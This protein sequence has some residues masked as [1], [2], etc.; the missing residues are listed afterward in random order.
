MAS[1][2]N[3]TPDPQKVFSE[4]INGRA[5]MLGLTI[6]LAVE[7]LTGKGI[8]EQLWSF[9]IASKGIDFSGLLGFFS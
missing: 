1:T 5:A 3:T 2:T 4:K 6:G 9:N 7:V 8:V